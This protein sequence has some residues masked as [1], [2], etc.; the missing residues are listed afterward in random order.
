MSA[1]TEPT[2]WHI[3]VSH[4]NEKVRW[5]LEFKGVDHERKAP[6]PPAHIPAAMWL[7][8][9]GSSTFPVLDLDGR[10]IGD[11]TAII[12]ALERSYPDPP[13]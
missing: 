6:P 13:L 2:L 8:R 7:T 1:D 11:S 3:P 9:G 4:Y 10:R 5:A 12:A